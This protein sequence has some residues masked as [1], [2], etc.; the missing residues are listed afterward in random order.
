MDTVYSLFEDV[1]LWCQFDEPVLIG[2]KKELYYHSN[3]GT[4]YKIDGF[5]SFSKIEE[6]KIHRL[7]ALQIIETK[8]G[9]QTSRYISC[10]FPSKNQTTKDD[11]L[12]LETLHL[13]D[14]DID[15]NDIDFSVLE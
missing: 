9:T 14:N 1:Y 4:K 15:I 5:R 11:I 2:K 12:K 3:D 8:T 13:N 7:V 6:S 10:L